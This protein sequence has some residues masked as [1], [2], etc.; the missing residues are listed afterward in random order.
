VTAT[1]GSS[2][3]NS[4]SATP[5]AGVTDPNGGNNSMTDIDAVGGGGTGGGSGIAQPIPT[6]SV[7]SLMWL[8]IAV[9]FVGL[10]SRRRV[11]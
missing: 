2:V 4:A 7:W 9:G 11:R 3:S 10:R 6:L 1:K 8:V 5:P